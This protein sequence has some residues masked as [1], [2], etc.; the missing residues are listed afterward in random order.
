MRIF[1]RRENWSSIKI[2]KVF[3]KMAVE[4][5]IYSKKSPHKFSD[6]N[7]SNL[8][9][10][11]F[12]HFNRRLPKWTTV[13]QTKNNLFESQITLNSPKK[14]HFSAL[15]PT[16]ETP[17]M[18]RG[19]SVMQPFSLQYSKTTY[20]ATVKT[21]SLDFK[22]QL[23]RVEVPLKQLFRRKIFCWLIFYCM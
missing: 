14:W 10:C 15:Y 11:W 18:F 3:T 20:S 22:F 16:K 12:T 2:E 8:T 7:P 17:K 4:S 23:N 19:C 1:L 9:I 21:F 6:I 13:V 5:A